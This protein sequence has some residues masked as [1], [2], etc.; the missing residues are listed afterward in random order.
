MIDT[1]DGKSSKRGKEKI[2][3]ETNSEQQEGSGKRQSSRAHPL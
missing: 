2:A 3:S 1:S